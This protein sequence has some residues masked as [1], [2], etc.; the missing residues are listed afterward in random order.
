MVVAGGENAKE[1]RTFDSRIAESVW[2][3]FTGMKLM[4]SEKGNSN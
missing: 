4:E 1:K 2:L 3:R